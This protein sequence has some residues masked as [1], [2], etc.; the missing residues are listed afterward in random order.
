MDNEPNKIVSALYKRFL[1]IRADDKNPDFYKKQEAVRSELANIIRVVGAIEV[2]SKL[3]ILKACSMHSSW[4]CMAH[5][6]F[7][8][9]LQRG[10][11][12]VLN[13]DIS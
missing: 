6:S 3:N 12:D 11:E 13:K 7:F 5:H 9:Y 8:I 1:A 2:M 10:C 4:P